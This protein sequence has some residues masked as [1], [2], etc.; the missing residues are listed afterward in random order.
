MNSAKF[1]RPFPDYVTCPNCHEPE[2]EVWC[3]QVR[4]RCHQ[5]GYTFEHLLPAECAGL[6]TDQLRVKAVRILPK[7]MTV[8]ACLEVIRRS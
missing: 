8:Y 6:C 2:V 3:Y 1:A 5:C 4:A 7:R